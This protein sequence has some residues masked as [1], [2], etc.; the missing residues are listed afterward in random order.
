[1]LREVIRIL[2]RRQTKMENTCLMVLT[3]KK[4]LLK[5]TEIS[6]KQRMQISTAH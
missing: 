1:M 5:A 6:E 3:I 2:K 4:I